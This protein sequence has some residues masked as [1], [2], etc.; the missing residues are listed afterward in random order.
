[1]NIT[2]SLSDIKHS[3]EHKTHQ[4]NRADKCD[5]FAHGALILAVFFLPLSTNFFYLFLISSMILFFLSGDIKQKAILCMQHPLARVCVGFYL[6]FIVAGCYS[7][8]SSQDILFGYNKM[9]KLLYIPMFLILM[10]EQ[11]WRWA[12]LLAF[13]LSMVFSLL[14]GVLKWKFMF[15]LLYFR[16]ASP[17]TVFKSYI[18]TNLMMA[19]SVFILAQGLF[20][21]IPQRFKYGMISLM[22]PMTLYVL[23]LSEGRS[24]YVTFMALWILFCFQHLNVRK[25]LLALL[26]LSLLFGSAF[27]CSTTFQER[28]YKIPREI[29]LYQE[30]EQFTSVGIRMQFVKNTFDLASERP[31]F[32]WGTG[33]FNK[34]YNEYAK[35]NNQFDTRNPHNEYLNV[36]FQLG[37]LGLV[38]LMGF[39]GV[40]LWVSFKLPLFEGHI[41]Q[42]ALLAMMIGCLANSWLMD[43]TAGY[44]FIIMFGLCAAALPLKMPQTKPKPKQ[45]KQTD[46]IFHEG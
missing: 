19:F 38:Y 42:G 13:M 30:G 29:K 23:W 40:I 16:H 1:M 9:A 22:V 28:M 3:A 17:A 18:D 43:S 26:G 44:F 39:F 21:N 27:L 6:L 4:M 8:G 2:C 31:I 15:P 10:R 7:Q 5:W 35:Q 34:I 14:M 32:G 12:G 46:E 45:V 24:G 41:I 37:G 36:F 11:K 33:S 20:L 25:T